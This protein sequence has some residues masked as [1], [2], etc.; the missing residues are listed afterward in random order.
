MLTLHHVITPNARNDILLNEVH[1]FFGEQSDSLPSHQ[2]DNYTPEGLDVLGHLVFSVL[3]RK[4]EI[5]ACCGIYNGG[6]YPPGVFRVLNRSF[7]S[8]Q[9]RRTSGLYD[10]QLSKLILSSQLV[11]CRDDLKLIFVSREGMFA[12]RFL[13]FWLRNCAPAGF[14]WQKSSRLVHVAPRGENRGCYQY[15]CYAQIQMNLDEWQPKMI[16]TEQ[17]KVLAAR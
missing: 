11:L 17:W 15:I 2:R 6:R 5:V 13:D 8:P 14:H 16:D 4:D 7:I 9:Q 1:R 3:K 12:S 10:C